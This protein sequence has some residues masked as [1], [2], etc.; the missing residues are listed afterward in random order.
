MDP[1]LGKVVPYGV[2]DLAKKQGWV[3]VGTDHDTLEFATDKIWSW[4]KSMKRRSSPQALELMI[5]AG[6]GGSNGSRSRLWKV[7]VQRLANHTGLKVLVCHFPSGT[8][9]WNKIENRFFS[10]FT[11]NWR[12]K[13][14]INHEVVVNLI[15]STTTRNGLNVKVKL[16]KKKYDT[17][18]KVSDE[19]PSRLNIKPKQFYGDWNY[20]MSPHKNISNCSS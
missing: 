13:P 1:Q 8:S 18:V 10:F 16:S 9:K 6:S 7:G 19:V 14:L 4:W 15:G 12:G 20:E 17:G 11:Q 5:L 3:T 2:Y